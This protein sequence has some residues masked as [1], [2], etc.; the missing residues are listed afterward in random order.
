MLLLFCV[1]RGKGYEVYKILVIIFCNAY[2]IG[3][4]RTE[5]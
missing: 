1:D 3:I 4:L 5:Q 2:N